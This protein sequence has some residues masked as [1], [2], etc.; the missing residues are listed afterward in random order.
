MANEEDVLKA[1]ETVPGPDGASLTAS[2]AV[3]GINVTGGKAFISIVGDPARPREW[4]ACTPVGG[5]GRWK[6]PR[7]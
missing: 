2:G 3:S 5:T 1:L 6:N 7:R 4:E